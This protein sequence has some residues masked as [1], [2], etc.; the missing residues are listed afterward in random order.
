MADRLA[1]RSRELRHEHAAARFEERA[2][3]AR[4]QGEI[5]RRVL[6]EGS[7]AQETAS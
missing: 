7:D 1:S 4:K 3:E 6:M 2:R 5:I